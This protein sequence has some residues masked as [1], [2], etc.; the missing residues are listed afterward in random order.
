MLSVVGACSDVDGVKVSVQKFDVGEAE[1]ICVVVVK[2]YDC[3]CGLGIGCRYDVFECG[4]KEF[5]LVLPGSAGGVNFV[6][7]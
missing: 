4:G 2:I 5:T 7:K 3:E 6:A 1:Y